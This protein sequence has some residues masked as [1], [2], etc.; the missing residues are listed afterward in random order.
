MPQPSHGRTIAMAFAATALAVFFLIQFRVIEWVAFAAERGRLAAVRASLTGDDAT[1]P[2]TGRRV[3][4]VVLPAVVSIVTQTGGPPTWTASSRADEP[5]ALARHDLEALLGEF[6]AR[7]ESAERDDAWLQRHIEESQQAPSNGR[8]AITIEQGLGSGFIFD[9]DRGYILTNSHVVD[10][11]SEVYVCLSDGREIPGDVLGSDPTTDLAVVRIRAKRLHEVPLGDSAHVAP[12]DAVIAVGTPFGLAGTVS[13][14]IIS[15]VNREHVVVGGVEHPGLLQTDALI[16]PG[17]S[18]GPL[19]NTRGEV[20]GINTAIATMNGRYDGI[21]FAIPAQRAARLLPDLIDG[22][23]GFLG[24][25]VGSVTDH[26]AKALALHWTE[27]RGTLVDS[28]MR[29][30]ASERAGVRPQDIIVAVD[31]QPIADKEELGRVISKRRPGTR[32]NLRVWRDDNFLTIPVDVDR[33][34]APR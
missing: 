34:F 11:A 29:G 30:R 25:M 2:D 26:R 10:R 22:G 33:R 13:K 9:A 18:G 24:I 20:I 16:S 6:F 3:A 31:G 14:G 8:D 12:G 32:A 7:G 21:G 19:V 23:P 28:V 1:R 5:G 15:A 17:H 27:E 4:Q